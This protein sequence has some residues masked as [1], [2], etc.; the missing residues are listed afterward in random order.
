[1]N[2]PTATLWHRLCKVASLITETATGCWGPLAWV[3]MLPNCSN[4][5]PRN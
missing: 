2:G 3:A 1:M 5:V 4:P